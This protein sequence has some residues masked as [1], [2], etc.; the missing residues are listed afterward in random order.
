MIAIVIVSIINI[1]RD[2]DARTSVTIL[3]IQLLFP[4]YSGLKYLQKSY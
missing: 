4:L 3:N 1:F 2:K